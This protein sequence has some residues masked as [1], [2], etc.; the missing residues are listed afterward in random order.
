MSAVNL[1][2]CVRTCVFLFVRL[3]VRQHSNTRNKSEALV[4]LGSMSQALATS[5]LASLSDMTPQPNFLLREKEKK[6][7]LT[8]L[9][10]NYRC[11]L[12]SV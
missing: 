10:L 9:T 4:H 6:K 5:R 11:N 2:V 7:T 8:D 3:R 12:T 1:S